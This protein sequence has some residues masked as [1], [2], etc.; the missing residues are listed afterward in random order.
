MSQA[1]LKV[2]DYLRWG[3][4]EEADGPGESLPEDSRPAVLSGFGRA[5]R[6][7]WRQGASRWKRVSIDEMRSATD[8][9]RPVSLSSSGRPLRMPAPTSSECSSDVLV[10][11]QGTFYDRP[12]FMAPRWR[13][14]QQPEWNF[15]YDLNVLWD[16]LSWQS[17]AHQMLWM[18]HFRWN[19]WRRMYG[20]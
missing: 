3:E 20:N 6:S 7:E 15:R 5:E 17:I 9:W 8:S 14:R 16:G 19:Q 11:R 4:E 18:N 2:G 1:W 13:Q 10:D 12:N